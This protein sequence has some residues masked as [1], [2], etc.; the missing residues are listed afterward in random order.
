MAGSYA[1]GKRW[2]PNSLPPKTPPQHFQE[3]RRAQQQLENSFKLLDNVSFPQTPGIRP[4]PFPFP[5]TFQ[6]YSQEPLALAQGLG[7]SCAGWAG[8]S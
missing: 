4:L 3:G 5:L 2:R 6:P 7:S 1:A 8:T